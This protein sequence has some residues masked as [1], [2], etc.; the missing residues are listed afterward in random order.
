VPRRQHRFRMGDKARDDREDAEE[1][2]RPKDLIGKAEQERR[3]RKEDSADTVEDQ[4]QGH[5]QK[6]EEAEFIGGEGGVQDGSRA[7]HDGNPL[8][9]RHIVEAEE[10]R[11]RDEGDT[12]E[13]VDCT[14]RLVGRKRMIIPQ[15]GPICAN[16]LRYVLFLA[17]IVVACG[18]GGLR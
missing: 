4:V 12:R 5:G 16:V 18:E 11:R 1:N 8:G 2:M 10:P 17:V 9:R 14:V 7:E 3:C 6:L 15:L 13:I